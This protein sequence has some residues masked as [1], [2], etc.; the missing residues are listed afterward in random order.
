[1][2]EFVDP[3]IEELQDRIAAKLGYTLRGHKLELYGVPKDKK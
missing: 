2:I 1:V 3:E